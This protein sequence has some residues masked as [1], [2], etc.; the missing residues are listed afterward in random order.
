MLIPDRRVADVVSRLTGVP[1][2]QITV[3]RDSVQFLSTTFDLLDTTEL[4]MEF[5]E[6]FDKETV[7]WALRYIAALSGRATSTQDANSEKARNPDCANPLWDR[8]L[9]P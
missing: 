3:S 8:D 1:A 6:E 9:D 4:I 5:E 7:Q 2:D